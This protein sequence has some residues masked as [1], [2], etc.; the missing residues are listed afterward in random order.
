MSRQRDGS[1]TLDPLLLPYL[2]ATEKVVDRCL[3]GIII[4]HAQP[5]IEPIMRRKFGLWVASDGAAPPL[6]DADD[7]QQDVVLS[8]IQVL[9]K[10]RQQPDKYGL[11]NF[12]GYVA[13]IT[14]N[15]WNLYLRQRF[16]KRARLKNRLRYLARLQENCNFRAWADETGETWFAKRTDGPNLPPSR[17]SVAQ[18]VSI[19]REN[20]LGYAQLP[21]EELAQVLLKYANGASRLDVVVSVVAELRH[22]YDGPPQDLKRVEF[23]LDNNTPSVEER[24]IWHEQL[25]TLWPQIQRLSPNHRSALLLSGGKGY[26]I[27]AELVLQHITGIAE[28]AAALSITPKKLAEIWPT[29]PWNDKRIAAQLSLQPQQV[30]AL[31][32]CARA[33]LWRNLKDILTLRY[34]WSSGKC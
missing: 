31:R 23:H 17:L 21:L 34:K 8:L 24:L 22:I 9:A 10:L 19:I 20:Y 1:H 2:A 26:D 32:R 7:L 13:R 3:E 27:V 30:I 25:D 29:L 11:P 28:L 14:Y 6:S 18:M 5:V 16:P 12:R 33:C 15:A 4:Q